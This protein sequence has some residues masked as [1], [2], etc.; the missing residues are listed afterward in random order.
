[1]EPFALFDA[2][3][4]VHGKISASLA[5]QPL[6][7]LLGVALGSAEGMTEGYV[8]GTE[9]GVTEGTSV[10]TLEGTSEGT[11]EGNA[12]GARLGDEVG[13]LVTTASNV[14]TRQSSV[15][16]TEKLIAD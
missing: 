13:L 11:L 10:G 7:A 14:E 2:D 6:G 8:V 5:K 16:S 9:L 4:R 3:T 1:M 12:D 15:L